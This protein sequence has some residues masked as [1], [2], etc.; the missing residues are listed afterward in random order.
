MARMP[1]AE[2]VGEHGST[3]MTEASLNK[4]C[5]HTIVG[6]PPAHA[7][8]FSV[9]ADGHIFQSRDTRYRSAAN[10]YG[11]DDVIAIENDDHG[12]EYG[13]WDTRDGHAVPG[14]TDAQMWGIARILAWG[15]MVHGIPLEQC[16]DSKDGSEGVAYHRQGIDGNFWAEGYA[17]GGRVAGGEEWSTSSGKVCPG[18]RR[19]SQQ[20]IIIKRA[21]Q[22][23][24]LDPAPIK[25]NE[26]DHMYFLKGGTGLGDCDIYL[27]TGPFFMGIAGGA[28]ADA[29]KAIQERNAPFQ[30]VTQQEVD[31][32]DRR[33]HAL[34]D[35]GSLFDL[36]K[37]H[38]TLMRDMATKLGELA[39]PS[40]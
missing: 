18:D 34:Y 11:N 30:W 20:P 35:K 9:R 26:E 27:Q 38:S 14:Y 6:N 1:G 5:L 22:L 31:D 28:R 10:L 13:A 24:G 40:A 23:A 12:P 25:K 7:A 33:S 37:E 3:P 39:P 17:Y 2:W 21:R 19:I 8:H 16:P 36:L 29:V 15:H 4:F 32:L